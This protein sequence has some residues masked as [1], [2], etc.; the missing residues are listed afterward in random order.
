MNGEGASTYLRHQYTLEEYLQVT[1]DQLS[2]R[3]VQASDEG[4]GGLTHGPS[5]KTASWCSSGVM[6]DIGGEQSLRI[7]PLGRYK[8]P[9]GADLDRGERMRD[10]WA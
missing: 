1:P 5:R 10:T 8:K 4:Y 6:V 3:Q 9:E 7:N 2:T